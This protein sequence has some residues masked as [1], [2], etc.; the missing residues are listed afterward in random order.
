MKKIISLMLVASFVCASVFSVNAASSTISISGGAKVKTPVSLSYVDFKRLVEDQK[1]P[2]G[3][4]LGN[5]ATK[6]KMDPT[7]KA[8]LG[9]QAT[10]LNAVRYNGSATNWIIRIGFDAGKNESGEQIFNN[11]GDYAITVYPYA[12]DPKTDEIT[13]LPFRSDDEANAYFAKAGD[14]Y[15]TNRSWFFFGL[16]DEVDHNS[17]GFAVA[18]RI[19]RWAD[20]KDL[21]FSGTT[22]RGVHY[23][24]SYTEGSSQNFLNEHIK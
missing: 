6:F 24:G 20:W 16:F 2:N 1:G 14:L 12:R 3:T 19:K 9:K 10:V 18:E 7:G 17:C 8:K 23:A 4:V 21:S 5:V 11:V 15:G 13:T 22:G